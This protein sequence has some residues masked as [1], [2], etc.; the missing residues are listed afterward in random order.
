MIGRGSYQDCVCP[1]ETDHVL[2]SIFLNIVIFDSNPSIG[3]QVMS[4]DVE[5]KMKLGLLFFA[6]E[7]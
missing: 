5:R 4:K 2:L 3:E 1:S 6:F 7:K